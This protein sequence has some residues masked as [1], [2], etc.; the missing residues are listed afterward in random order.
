[1]FYVFSL[2]I[3]NGQKENCYFY[4]WLRAS[5]PERGALIYS[6]LQFWIT[7]PFREYRF[8][9][10]WSMKWGHDSI[11]NICNRIGQCLFSQF[12]FIQCS[13]WWYFHNTS[14][15]TPVWINCVYKYLE[16]SEEKYVYLFYFHRSKTLIL[17]S[18]YSVDCLKCSSITHFIW[19]GKELGHTM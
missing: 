1:M 13:L 8:C 19:L 18:F 14:Y 16:F 17:F 5:L 3:L 10:H 7:L 15:F 6:L 2:W 4:L 11:T 9:Y 12:L